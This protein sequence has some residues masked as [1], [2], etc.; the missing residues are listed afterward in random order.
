M[1]S[2]R[3]K[4]FVS[5]VENGGITQAGEELFISQPA[6][7]KHLKKLQ[8]EMGSQL[9][10]FRHGREMT[11]SK[12][13][14]ILYGYCKVVQELEQKLK[15]ELLSNPNTIP[16]LKGKDPVPPLCSD[17]LYMNSKE[18]SHAVCYLANTRSKRSRIYEELKQDEAVRKKI[19]V[20]GGRR[21]FYYHKE[22][23]KQFIAEKFPNQLS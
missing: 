10:V 8:D 2:H 13:G 22:D 9:I 12:H 7:T 6:V 5:I 23:V 21:F 19:F 18:L 1:L 15:Y 3:L 11:L 16:E 20:R 4:V 14:K 17:S